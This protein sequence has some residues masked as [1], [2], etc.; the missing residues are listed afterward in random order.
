MLCCITSSA[1][2]REFC[3]WCIIL[4]Q[5]NLSLGGKKSKLGNSASGPPD[6]FSRKRKQGSLFSRMVASLNPLGWFGSGKS[7]A[8][9]TGVHEPPHARPHCSRSSAD[10]Y[11]TSTIKEICSLGL[12][13]RLS[14]GLS[15]A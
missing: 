9:D 13:A 5:L 3:T 10:V 7:N 12:C 1:P 14:A 15:L 6:F 11:S 4:L 8:V 2:L